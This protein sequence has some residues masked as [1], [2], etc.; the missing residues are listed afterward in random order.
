ML[1]MVVIGCHQAN[2]GIALPFPLR[3]QLQEQGLRN[4]E[5]KRRETIGLTRKTN[6][7]IACTINPCIYVKKPRNLI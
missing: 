6:E 1:P 4:T 5:E 2:R 3:L 7:K